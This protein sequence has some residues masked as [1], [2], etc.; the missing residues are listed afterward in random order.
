MLLGRN[1]ITPV[2]Q[3][4]F[5]SLFIFVLAKGA[6]TKS[7]P[8]LSSLSRKALLARRWSERSPQTAD[9]YYDEEAKDLTKKA[10]T[11]SSFPPDNLDLSDAWVEIFS[12]I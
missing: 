5:A 3:Q 8:A 4:L 9:Y 7:M 1:P 2:Y 12:K 10:P 11:S 6:E